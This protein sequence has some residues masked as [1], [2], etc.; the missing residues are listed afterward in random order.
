[1]PVELA[2]RDIILRKKKKEIRE[3]PVQ[4]VIS[5]SIILREIAFRTNLSITEIHQGVFVDTLA[6]KRGQ[7]LWG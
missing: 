4:T 7:H 6:C 1:M 5:N 3:I 2:N